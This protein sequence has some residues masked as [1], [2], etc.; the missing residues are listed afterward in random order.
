MISQLQLQSQ[1]ETLKLTIAGELTES[2]D[3]NPPEIGEQVT[4]IELDLEGV[5]SVN[6]FGV[7]TWMTFLKKLVNLNIPI[8]LVN[9][10][11]ACINQL[12]MIKNFFFDCSIKSFFVPFYCPSC[13]V[14]FISRQ[15]NAHDV[16][17][18][19]TCTH[20]GEEADLDEDPGVYMFMESRKNTNES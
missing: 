7:R 18:H 14:E 20:C 12:S 5:E 8:D 10:S 17:E 4:K 3:L 9:V 6:S 15:E 1:T 19:T 2:S 16:S 11:H 13:D